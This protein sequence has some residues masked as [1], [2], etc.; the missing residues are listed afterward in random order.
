MLILYNY[1]WFSCR[2]PQETQM[3]LL[4][5][6]NVQFAENS[7]SPEMWYDYK[8]YA[9]WTLIPR[10]NKYTS[11]SRSNCRRTLLCS[12]WRITKNVEIKTLPLNRQRRRRTPFV[13]HQI[14]YSS[15]IEASVHVTNIWS[16]S[17]IIIRFW[18]ASRTALAAMFLDEITRLFLIYIDC[19][20]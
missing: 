17:C 9:F 11:K 18:K 20:A 1:F 3:W 13:T 7:A 15:K 6:D 2:A 10:A 12:C 14:T 16:R 8:Q 19:L 4:L 5:Q